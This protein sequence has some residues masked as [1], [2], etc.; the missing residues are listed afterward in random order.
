MSIFYLVSLTIV[1]AVVCAFLASFSK[2][3]KKSAGSGTYWLRFWS[4]GQEAGFNKT[5]IRLLK[6]LAKRTNKQNP[7]ALFWSQVQLD[8]CI[9]ILVNDLKTQNT[10]M[11]P[12]NQEFLSHLFNFRKKIEINKINQKRGLDSTRDI[13]EFQIIQIFVRDVGMFKSK[14]IKIGA[15]DFS[16]E[17]PD[18]SA[19]PIKFKWKKKRATVYF[20]R[21]NDAG[22]CFES[23]I[24]EEVFSGGTPYLTLAHTNKLSRTQSRTSLRVKTHRTALLYTTEDKLDDDSVLSAVFPGI[25]CF[26]EDVS[27][28]GCCVKVAGEFEAGIR[29]IVQFDLDNTTLSISGIVR[30]IDTKKQKGTSMLHIE[31]DIIPKEVKNLIMGV[32]FGAI[33]EDLTAAD[34]EAEKI[35]SEHCIDPEQLPQKH[36]NTVTEPNKISSG[37]NGEK[38]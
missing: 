5:E 2:K 17:R 27:D 7:A 30:S 37:I 36:E 20:W 9:K 6:D 29:V 21:L 34:S 10:E 23:Y 1:L 18:S 35:N 11:L 32:M 12:E 31:S 26:L 24:L 15:K 3:T 25:K 13:S 33:D 16:I 22:Y 19:L 4:K 8:E 14:I 28:S 38:T